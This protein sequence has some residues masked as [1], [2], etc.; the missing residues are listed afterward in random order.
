MSAP[1]QGFIARVITWCGL[2]PGVTIATS[3]ALALAS[4]AA[5][6]ATPVD[7]LPD[8]SDRQVIV[9][10]EWMGRSPALVEDQLTWPLSSTLLGTPGVRAVRGQS[11]PGM[12]FLYVV[13]E[14]DAD[15]E[16]AR[17]RVG[18]TLAQLRTSLPDDARVR[19]GPDASGVGWV[20]QYALVDD[21]GTHSLDA[22]RAFQDF[23]L[24]YAL[25]SVRG[26]AE[27]ASVG[28]Y[29]REVQVM[30]RPDALRTQGIDAR[31]VSAA[32]RA[33]NRDVGAGSITIAGRELFV[34]G[35][36]ALHDAESIGDVVLASRGAGVVVRVRDVAHVATGGRERRGIGDL[37]G[38]GETVS[39]IVV[40]REGA[41]ARDVIRDV[42]AR[43]ESL[44]GTLQRS[45]CDAIADPCPAARG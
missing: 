16:R 27:V 33:A 7:A 13:L 2:H 29:E 3:L 14:D 38:R 18:E 26:V 35:R 1:R 32:I 21:S 17:M 37:D 20:Y 19:V 9:V 12:S 34:R 43:L 30:L 25:Q 22:L 28:G 39:G 24:R 36:G 8:I 23:T 11:M 5:I 31:D 15:L 45:T 40:A 6:R 41:N 10:G 44:A 4:S 42:E